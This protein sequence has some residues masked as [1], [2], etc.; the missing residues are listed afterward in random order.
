MKEQK[1]VVAP[2]EVDTIITDWTTAKVMCDPRMTGAKGMSAVS[3]YFE[4]GQGHARH[5]HEESEQIIFV[6]SGEGEQI[7]EL[8]PGK[9]VK[10]KLSAGSLVFIPK[11]AYHSTFNTGWEPMRV[12]AV[13]SPPGPEAFMREMGDTGGIGAQELR[14]VPAGEVPKRR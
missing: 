14:V 12:L 1:V 6:V 5:N 9:I 4:P 7:V 10:Q 11:G 3:L 8:E 2:H 13:F